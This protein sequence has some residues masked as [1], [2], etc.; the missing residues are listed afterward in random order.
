MSAQ[1]YVS[2]NEPLCES[3]DKCQKERSLLDDF[4]M[5]YTIFNGSFKYDYNTNKDWMSILN[6]LNLIFFT[7]MITK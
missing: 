3:D 7:N 2:N 4:G 6:I 5:P 1:R